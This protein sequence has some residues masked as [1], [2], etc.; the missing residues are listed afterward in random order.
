MDLPVKGLSIDFS[1]IGSTAAYVCGL[2]MGAIA[3]EVEQSIAGN[4]CSR[5]NPGAKSSSNK[6]AYVLTIRNES[7]APL[8]LWWNDRDAN[9]CRWS[10]ES[11]QPGAS[12]GVMTSFTSR[13]GQWLLKSEGGSSAFPPPGADNTVVYSENRLD[14]GTTWLD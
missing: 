7:K 14:V 6:G 1:P 9:R 5:V 11:I 8:D 10:E 12:L 3:D 13:D 4:T 2:D